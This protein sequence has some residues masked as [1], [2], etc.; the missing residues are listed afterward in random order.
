[1]NL[2]PQGYISEVQAAAA[3]AAAHKRL[4]TLPE[5]L[6]ACQ[7]PNGW[8]Y[9]YGNVYVAGACNEGRATNPVNDCFGPGDSVFTSANMNSSCCDDQPHT[10]AP[11]GSFPM[12]VSAWGIYDLHGNLHEWIDATTSAGHGIF[13]GGYFVDAT[14]NGP[15]CL[16][17]TTAHAQSY[18]DYS[19]G[20][21]CCADPQ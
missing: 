10:V 9:P 2:E 16:Y 14:I 17:A 19:T 1:M 3:C 6:A 5:W 8:T 4:C 7:G 13:K 18:H 12:C 11:G 15:G 20:F 21:R